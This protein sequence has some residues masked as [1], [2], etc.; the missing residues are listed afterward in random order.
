[1][2][3]FHATECKD[4]DRPCL[5]CG[6]KRVPRILYLGKHCYCKSCAADLGL[7]DADDVDREEIARVDEIVLILEEAKEDQEPFDV[8]RR[9]QCTGICYG[10]PWG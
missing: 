3:V 5:E 2:M 1:M 7:W 9:R 10:A 4:K 8:W 6:L